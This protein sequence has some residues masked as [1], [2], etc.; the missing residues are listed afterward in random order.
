MSRLW[1]QPVE[2]RVLTV[3]WNVG[4]PLT[5]TAS[6]D[7]ALSLTPVFAAVR[8]I[9][10]YC[11]T[12]PV[13][14]YRKVGDDRL[15]MPLPRLFG[16]LEVQGRLV[17][18]LS[19]AVSSLVLRGNAV[20][21]KADS[22]GLGFPTAIQWIPMDLVHVDTSAPTPQWYINGQ[23]VARTD[24]VHIPWMT[25][26]G[27]ILGLSPIEY[28][29]STVSAGVMAQKFGLDWFSGG[30]F[31]PAVFQNSEKTLKPDEAAGIREKLATAIRKRQPLVTGKD[32]T[33]TP[34]LIPPEQAQFIESQKLSANQV[35][36]IY[37]LDPDEVGGEAANGLTYSNEESRQIKRASNMR[38][39]LVR[40]ERAFASL[41][42]ERQFVRF[43]TD[44]T[45]RAD[46]KTR[47]DVHRLRFEMGATSINEIR[48]VEDEPPIVGGDEF[49]PP[50]PA[51]VLAA[52]PQ[53][54]PAVRYL[55]AVNQG[56]TP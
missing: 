17:P 26:P 56:E 40:F 29:A 48:T 24:I 38:P 53:V 1:R 39:Y 20:G 44:A 33:Y 2:Q 51:P 13:K 6:Q 41:L 15:P 37:G 54:D 45:I 9:T 46:L 22:S 10:D 25:L 31:P 7:T 23:R 43:N 18:W 49:G 16:D 14:G 50:A 36:A 12:L 19:Q 27:Q 5:V 32:W 34:V 47:W 11:S 55:S 35:A 8:H 4:N 30:G 42:P 52:P 21:V 3:P 28:Y